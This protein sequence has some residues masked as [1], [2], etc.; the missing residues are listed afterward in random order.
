MHVYTPPGY[1]GAA[2]HYPV[3]YLLHGA[4]DDDSGWSTIGRAGFILDNL[5]AEKKAVPM[6]V[7]M[8]NGSMPRPAN[9]PAFRP[10]PRRSRGAR[11]D[12]GRPE[13][14]H[15]RAAQGRRPLRRETLPHEQG[16]ENRAI[17]G[18]SMGGGQ[19][20]PFVTTHPDEF[21]Y[22]G[23]WSAGLFGGNRRRVRE[24]Q[25]AFLKDADR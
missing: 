2:E 23:V 14:V 13:P 15:R 16:T 12:G 1:E 4:G 19:T 20:L 7:V 8:P 5:L 17:A 11:R 24:A 3:F 22:V 9:L 21:G 10:A 6:I 18:L 25:R